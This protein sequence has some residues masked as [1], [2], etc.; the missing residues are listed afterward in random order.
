V[1]AQL[2]EVHL[3]TQELIAYRDGCPWLATWV[4]TGQPALPTV[5]G[6]FHIF[7]K[8][9]WFLMRSPWPYGSPYWYPDTWVGYAMEIYND[10]TFLHTADWEP[11][12]AFGRGSEY[13]PYASHGCIHVQDGPA[14]TLFA[15]APIGTE[16][17]VGD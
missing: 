10:G 1:P 15:W 11:P 14:A 3:G 6:T 2:I 8:A 16:V 12:S 4:T 17:I 5:R 9:R 13:G 7:Y